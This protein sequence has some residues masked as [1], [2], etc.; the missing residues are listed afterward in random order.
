MPWSGG[1]EGCSVFPDGAA[2]GGEVVEAHLGIFAGED[3]AVGVAFECPHDSLVRI[4]RGCLS[5]FFAGGDID[6]DAREDTAL[7]IDAGFGPLGLAQDIVGGES[8]GGQGFY[9]RLVGIIEQMIVEFHEFTRRNITENA[10][11]DVVDEIDISL[12]AAVIIHHY[13]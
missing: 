13:F 1:F 10:L 12:T 11:T 7:A 3:D 8:G 5:A 9:G 2:G 6:I 4:V